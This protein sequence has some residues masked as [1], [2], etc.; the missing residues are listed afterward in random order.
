[1]Y[2]FDSHPREDHP[3][4][5]RSLIQTMSPDTIID[6]AP[7]YFQ[8]APDWFHALAN[9]WDITYHD[10]TG[11][12]KVHLHTRNRNIKVFA[13]SVDSFELFEQTHER[14]SYNVISNDNSIETID[15][16][17]RSNIATSDTMDI[18]AA[19]N[20]MNSD[21]DISKNSQIT[22][23]TNTQSNIQLN[24][25]SKTKTKI[26]SK[27]QLSKSYYAMNWRLAVPSA[28]RDEFIKV[29]DL[30]KSNTIFGNLNIY[31]YLEPTNVLYNQAPT[32]P[33]GVYTY[34]VKMDRLDN[35]KN[36]MKPSIYIDK[37][38][39]LPK[40]TLVINVRNSFINTNNFFDSL[41]NLN[42][43]KTNT[44]T[45]ENYETFRNDVKSTIYSNSNSD[46]N[47]LDKRDQNNKQNKQYVGRI[48][49]GEKEDNSNSNPVYPFVW[50]Y[51]GP[52]DNLKEYFGY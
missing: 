51:D 31:V 36:Y 8:K 34:D 35:S 24:T 42:G 19:N 43:P 41:T 49:S 52:I 2:K 4:N 18:A 20:N 16:D 10:S 44:N 13:G 6:S 38:T 45:N 27:T 47:N 5:I 14:T 25:Q 40:T 15:K 23:L 26:E 30:S 11:Q 21:N 9:E 22:T 28:L 3:A 32:L 17:T 7:Y 48:I 33:V 46:D 50:K 37:N 12:G 39:P 29:Q 1:M